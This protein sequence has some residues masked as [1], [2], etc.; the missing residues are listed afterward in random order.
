MKKLLFLMILSLS[1]YAQS[2]ND[3]LVYKKSGQRNEGKFIKMNRKLIFFQFEGQDTPFEI[4]KSNVDS[5]ISGKLDGRS[6]FIDLKS[7]EVKLTEYGKK[8]AAEIEAEKLRV[9]MD[10]ATTIKIKNDKSDE[11]FDL[12]KSGQMAVI[13]KLSKVTIKSG[14]GVKKGWNSKPL[15]VWTS[16]K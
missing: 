3:I 13:T 16:F 4:N 9:E 11:V 5:L 8:F 10:F 15:Q 12:F 14:E 2:N 7:G 1:V 6:Y